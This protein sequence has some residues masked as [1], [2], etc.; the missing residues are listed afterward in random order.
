MIRL[1]VRRGEIHGVTGDRSSGITDIV[2]AGSR[3]GGRTL[4]RGRRSPGRSLRAHPHAVDPPDQR[5]AVFQPRRLGRALHRAA[6]E[7]PR[8]HQTSPD[9]R[10]G[11]RAGRAAAGLGPADRVS[12]K[13]FAPAAPPASRLGRAVCHGRAVPEARAGTRPDHVGRFVFQQHGARFVFPA[14][15]A[16][17]DSRMES[18]G[19]AMGLAGG[20]AVL[21]RTNRHLP[22][23]AKRGCF[24][25]HAGT[26]GQ[27]GFRRAA[28]FVRARQPAG[29]RSVAGRDSHHGGHDFVASRTVAPRLASAADAGMGTFR[30]VQFRG[31]RYRGAGGRADGGI[32]AFHAGD[33]RQRGTLFA[34]AALAACDQSEKTGPHAG[35]AAL[36]DGWC[37]A[38]RIAGRRHGRPHA[39]ALSGT[40]R[41]ATRH[42]PGDGAHRIGQDH[43][44]V[45]GTLAA[46][47]PCQQHHD[48]G[49]LDRI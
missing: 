11:R 46:R 8:T 10:S 15:A 39:G 12:C 4:R 33:V 7:P 29:S 24:H 28:Q 2:M 1:R 47:C 16:R 23:A 38:A 18:G 30:G 27:S 22:L 43:H 48:G 35:R 9:A 41:A 20:R 44:L 45:C 6:G 31:G 13:G 32:H 37:G 40:D 42:H 49:R 34:A 36:V 3:G 26:R 19:R 25:R 14:A 21:P 5:G 17:R